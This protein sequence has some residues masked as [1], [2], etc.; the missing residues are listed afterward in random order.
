MD[1]LK[2]NQSPVSLRSEGDSPSDSESFST[3]LK[4]ISE[5]LMEEE[6]LERKSLMLKDSLALQAAEKSFYDVLGQNYPS[7]KNSGE[8]ESES[9][10]FQTSFSGS[11][12]NTILVQDSVSEVQSVVNKF[13]G[14]TGE[15]S[16]FFSKGK[17]QISEQERF[18]RNLLEYNLLNGLGRKKN[19]QRERGYDDQ[20]E[21]RRNKHSAVFGDDSEPIEMFDKVLLYD[22]D[23]DETNGL[24]KGK[25]NGG[26]EKLQRNEQAR[27]F[28]KTSRSKKQEHKA[29]MVDLWTLLSQCAQAVA[30][31]DQRTATDLLKQIRQHSSPC[32]DPTQRLAHYFADGLEVRLT[33]TRAA[34]Y[35]P[36]VSNEMSSADILRGHRVYITACPF[37]RM[38]FCLA[39]RTIRKLAQNAKRI[40][41]IDF[42]IQYGFQWPGLIQRLSRTPGGPPKLRITG[43]ELPQPGF[44]PFER[45]VETKRR[46]EKYCKR[47]GVPSEFNVIA[48]KWETIRY[49]DLNIGGD[50]IVVVNCMYRMKHIPD[51]TVVMRN[52]RDTV[53]K[54][55][56]RINPALFIHGVCNGT[57]NAPF[58]A[59]RF[60]EV[61]FHYSSLFDMFDTT[62]PREDE[63][64]ILFEK[65]IYGRDI[66]NV[67]ACEGL[68]RVERPETY[69]QWQ[70]RNTRAGFKQVP[71]DRE[72]F[73]KVRNTV[74]SS[75]HKDFVVEQH[76][77]WLVQGWKGRRTYAI[78]CWKP[79]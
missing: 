15:E 3:T 50:E 48:Q 62:V 8:S 38:S 72:I 26:T 56:R 11:S 63:Y 25:L 22:G 24:Y 29:E 68:E 27:R 20:E 59:T 51:E 77:Q 74:S 78:S 75:Y 23:N 28:G 64:R 45:V 2:F 39:N 44:R 31:Y 49:E 13:R 76:G 1:G 12:V 71:L 70:V 19:N 61:L 57:Y 40:H 67:I 4:F 54:L 69:K 5:M 79:A 58:F 16:S 47:F 18:E 41:I 43:V 53:L 30:G 21:G 42:G 32:G 55:I 66:V 60:R 7:D 36:L 34:S 10:S 14:R 9:S 65:A 73:E 6:D 46:L 35:S 52:P 33:G 37:L 17:A